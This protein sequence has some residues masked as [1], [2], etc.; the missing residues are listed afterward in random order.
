MR[1]FVMTLRFKLAALYVLVFAVILAVLCFAVLAIWE[2][3][4]LQSIDERLEERADSAVAAAGELVNTAQFSELMGDVLPGLS[5]LRMGKTR[6]FV[7]VRDGSGKS[8]ARSPNLGLIRL[9]LPQSVTAMKKSGV[10]VFTSLSD[11][12][13]T[14]LV[15]PPGELRYVSRYHDI[16]GVRPFYLQVGVSMSTFYA[17]GSAL[18]RLFM[19]IVPL[20]LLV[21]GVASWLLARRSLAPIRRIAR[22]ARALTAAHLDRRID[23]APT[24]DE[25]GE[26]V[27]TVNQMLDRLERAFQAQERFIA[28]AAHELKTPVAVVLGGG[29]VLL[30]KTRSP[31]EYEDYLRTVRDEMQSLGRL[32]DSMLTLSRADAGMPLSAKRPVHLNDVVTGVVHRWQRRAEERGIRLVLSLALPDANEP[33]P[34]VHGDAELID[35]LISNLVQNGVRYSP[36]GAVVEVEIR[37]AAERILLFVRDHGPGIPEEDFERVFERFYRVRR[38][39]HGETGTGLGLAIARGVAALHG[40]TIEAENRAGGGCEFTVDLPR[41]RARSGGDGVD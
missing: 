12:D 37:L 1:Q 40:G 39:E 36:S 9:P 23:A 29:Q 16:P 27:E 7:Q 17:S 15:G 30:Q 32:V 5:M 19:M 3:N 2:R 22:E 34:M 25:V 41:Y 14:L 38:A 35:S 11:D 24:R 13:A 6:Y 21:A 18:R 4:V 26:L 20:G 8:L 33:E 28:D 31:Q 10:S